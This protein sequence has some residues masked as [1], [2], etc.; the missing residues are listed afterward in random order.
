[1][2]VKYYNYYITLLNMIIIDNYI[3][4]YNILDEVD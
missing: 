1:M 4:N 2:C 3:K